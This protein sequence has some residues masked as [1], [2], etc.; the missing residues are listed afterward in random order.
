MGA[1]FHFESHRFPVANDRLFGHVAIS[2]I[3]LAQREAEI[4]R[5]GSLTRFSAFVSLVD[6]GL[7]VAV[8]AEAG[9]LGR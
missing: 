2:N 8:F 7:V 9:A 4:D 3:F 6:S 5:C 1:C